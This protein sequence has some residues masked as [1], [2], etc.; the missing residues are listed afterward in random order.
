M[1]S[2]IINSDDGVI[3]GTSGL[4]TTG[5]DDG[6]LKLQ[7]KGTDAVTVNA[8]QVVT[9][10]NALPVASGGTGQ[11]TYTN[12]Q[13]LIGSTPTNGLA[14]ATLTAGTGITVTNGAGTITIASTAGGFTGMVAYSSPATF[15]APPTTNYVMVYAMSGGGGGGGGTNLNST[16]GG[17]GGQG[18]FG[19]GIYPV[20]AGSPYPVTVGAGGNGGNVSNVGSPAPAGNA[21]GASSFGSLLTVNGANAGNGGNASPGSGG[22]PGNPGNTGTAPLAQVTQSP[23]NSSGWNNSG[24]FTGLLGNG[25]GYLGGGGSGGPGATGGGAGVGGRIIVFY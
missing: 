8:T 9:L 7:T 25:A 21:G 17:D 14:K 4:K 2:S 10:A 1:P 6:V 19:A 24:V 13:L 20:T 22:N 12:G 18:F 11:T 23:T 16:S 5:G 15:T 3:S